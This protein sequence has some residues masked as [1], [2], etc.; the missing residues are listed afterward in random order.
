MGEIGMAARYFKVI[1]EQI[2]IDKK[3]D[4]FKR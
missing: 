1:D 3:Q 2:I 4:W